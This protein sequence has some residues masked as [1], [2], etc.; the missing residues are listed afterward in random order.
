MLTTRKSSV[1]ERVMPV[2]RGGL[3][4]GIREKVAKEEKRFARETR[5]IRARGRVGERPRKTRKGTEVG[6]EG[7]T[8]VGDP[9]WKSTIRGLLSLIPIFLIFACFAGR[10]LDGTFGLFSKWR[11]GLT[12]SWRLVFCLVRVMP[13]ERLDLS[14]DPAPEPRRPLAGRRFVGIHFAC[15]D[16]YARVYINQDETAYLGRCPACLRQV[17]LT[18]GPGGTDERFFTAY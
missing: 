4:R 12:F 18:V 3:N 7:G 16:R 9:R 6:E 13:G 17:R 14:S 15:C 5:Q 2:V 10:F 8:G 1:N 11:E